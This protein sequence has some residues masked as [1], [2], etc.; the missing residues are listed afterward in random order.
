[1]DICK[2]TALE[3]AGKIHSKE[4]MIKDALDAVYKNIDK[5]DAEYNCY[6]STCREPAYRR[7]VEI[8][9]RIDA[10]EIISALAG[11]PVSVKDNICT[12]DIET[13]CAS[14]MLKNFKP[15]YSASV[16]D[17]MEAADMILIGKLN[18][19]EFAMGSTSETSYF[20]EISNPWDKGR[21]PGGSSG[22]AAASVSAQ[23]AFLSLG[24]DT[25][26]SIR[27]PCS[28]CGVT[29]LKPTY[30]SVSRYGLIAYASSL[31]Q[32]GPIAKDVADC[33]ALF[34]I[35]SGKDAKDG[36]S[37]DFPKFEYPNV[38]NGSIK[39][40]KIGI[41]ADYL[42]RGISC[43][44]KDAILNAKR[45]L[46]NLGAIVEEFAMPIVKYA[47]PAYYI[48]ACA[49]AC[50]NLSR[51]DG[52]KYGYSSPL[53]ENLKDT[54]IKSRSEGLGMEVKRRIMLGNFVLSSGYYDSYYKKA[55]MAKKLIQQSFF[56]AFTKYD[57][58]LGPVAPTT[59]LK[60]GE[61]LS[62]P[63]K[64]YLGDI[65]TVMINIA[66]LPAVS[67]PCGFDK[68]NLPIGMQ[69]IGKP[70]DETTILQAAYVF[71]KATDFLKSPAD[72]QGGLS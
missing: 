14:L 15:I 17:K 35:I 18:M 2:M 53:A 68:D 30:G 67:V 56:D 26:G 54:Y 51:Y 47:I 16:I 37:M 41:P 12:K 31:D 62:D 43:D 48:I 29:G 42:G 71:Q 69:L 24:S 3:L 22:G 32:I 13:T 64:M 36:T 72:L 4:I 52:I 33:A 70:F 21:V 25:G 46:E 39:G 5:F 60:K 1:M 11:V 65:Y 66:G 50:S 23:E 9:A 38:T 49:E 58:L 6:I 55:L 57:I 10:G 20:G 28:F 19:D 8:Q 45:E 44:V 34:E 27:Q 63:L 59:A 7:A 40:K 61:S